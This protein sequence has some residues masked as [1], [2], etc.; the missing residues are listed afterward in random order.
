MIPV[1]NCDTTTTQRQSCACSNVTDGDLSCNCTRP[2]NGIMSRND[3]YAASSCL[4]PFK[5]ASF[6][7]CVP[8]MTVD[9][10]IPTKQCFTIGAQLGQNVTNQP[11]RCSTL[12]I[13]TTNATTN[14]TNRSTL[15]NCQ[16]T[17]QDFLFTATYNY[18][19]D[20]C[21]VYNST[22]ADCCVTDN[23]RVQQIPQLSCP[24]GLAATTGCKCQSS[25]VNGRYNRTCGCGITYQSKAYT[26]FGLTTA[27]DNCMCNSTTCGCCISDA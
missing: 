19:T 15:L 10:Q 13:T 9:R 24:A 4:A 21:L 7:C 14:V 1:L 25:I 18:T 22:V 12:N 27:A 20:R 26:V 17:N 16:C 6:Q 8:R 23:E 5:N 3:R 2:D 11:C